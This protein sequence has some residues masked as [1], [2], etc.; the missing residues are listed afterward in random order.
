MST[1]LIINADDYGFSPGVTDGILRSH[2]Q[3]ILTSATLITTMPDAARAVELARAT[4]TLGV[5]V[6]LCLTQG[7]PRRPGQRRLLSGDGVFPDKVWKLIARISRGGARML[8]EVRREWSAQI[9]YAL[10]SG[11]QPTHLDSHKHVHHWPPL[12]DIAIALAREHA[13]HFIR[14]AGEVAIPG[15]PTPR[16]EYRL[17]L[18][19]AR[20]LRRKIIEADLRTSDWFFGL[21]ATGRMATDI[22]LKLLAAPPAGTGEIMVH[23]GDPQGLQKTDSRLLSERRIEMDALC[24]LSVREALEKSGAKLAHYG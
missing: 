20:V 3:G 5:G 10:K 22:W 7:M 2:R 16:M 6:H 15:C 18:R 4:P 21:A 11:L 1:R 13:I 8:H 17:L 24:D 23:P 14:C 19:L 9:D 12:A